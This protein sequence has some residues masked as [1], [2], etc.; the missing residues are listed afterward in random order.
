M[1]IAGTPPRISVAL[2]TYNGTR[3]LQE[4]LDS[5]AAQ[6]RQPFELIVTD[7]RST[8]GTLE[9][10]ERFAQTS[11]FPVRIHQN[12]VQLRSTRNF[13]QAIRLCQGDYIAL[14]DQ[15][16]RWAPE[17]L[18]VLGGQL[19]QDPSVG[20]VFSDAIL[21]DSASQPTGSTLWHSLRFPPDTRAR[22]AR[23]PAAVLLERPVV[24][25]ATVLFRRSLL[26]HFASIPP[27][28][29][30]DGWITWMSVLWARVLFVEQPVTFYRVHA[31]QQLGVGKVS[32]FGRM[33]EIRRKQ[34]LLYASIATEFDLLVRYIED[35]PALDR[36]QHWRDE[37]ARTA[38]FFRMRAE[39]PRNF[40]ARLLFLARHLSAYQALSG[41][42]WRILVRDLF[43]GSPEPR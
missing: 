19:D 11:P 16:D 29:V 25:G 37:I 23:D 15:D 3:Y 41:P 12:P 9:L 6:T 40:A 8:D 33:S 1:S 35:S 20:M 4:Q 43:M 5:I 27:E 42:T 13:D 32:F 17:K 18:A 36:R 34:R 7:D 30:H 39:S 10:L 14:S 2:C 28:W 31:S 22:F 21:I 38:A 26:D 24:T